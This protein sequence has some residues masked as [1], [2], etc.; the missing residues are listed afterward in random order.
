MGLVGGFGIGLLEEGGGVE[1]RFIYHIAKPSVCLDSQVVLQSLH[2]EAVG[3]KFGERAHRRRQSGILGR[4]SP[5]CSILPGFDLG[6]TCRTSAMLWSIM[7]MV[8]RVD[9]SSIGEL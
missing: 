2:V 4:S 8:I 5:L 9:S 3:S 1:A 6:L 7:N